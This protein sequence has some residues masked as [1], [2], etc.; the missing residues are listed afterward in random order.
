MKIAFV[1]QLNAPQVMTPAVQIAVLHRSPFKEVCHKNKPDNTKRKR[2]P[3][4]EYHDY[5]LICDVVV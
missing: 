4:R 1:R 2:T 3:H 5:S